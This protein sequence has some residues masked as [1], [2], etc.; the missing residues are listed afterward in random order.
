M[1]IKG[2]TPIRVGEA[3]LARRQERYAAL[4]PPIAG[5]H[6][7]RPSG[8]RRRTHEPGLGGGDQGLRAVRDRRGACDGSGFVRRRRAGLR[9]RPGPGRSQGGV[10][11]PRLRAC[12]SSPPAR[13]SRSACGSR[14]SPAT[15]PS[16]TSCAPASR[17]TVT[18]SVST[19]T[20]CS[21]STSPTSP[22]TAAGTTPLPRLWERFAGSS[23]DG[24]HQ[25]VLRRR[26]AGPPRRRGQAR[27]PDRACSALARHRRRSRYSSPAPKRPLCRTARVDVGAFARRWCAPSGAARWT[28][29]IWS[30]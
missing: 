18:S 12:S 10:A 27:G 15:G 16:A 2:I 9:A 28:G 19:A 3:E 5:F 8:G 22:T 30:S 29:R 1:K 7:L 24:G 11:R 25:R 21:T 6:A 23:H 14:P 4:A 13:C 20:S 17:A 26:A